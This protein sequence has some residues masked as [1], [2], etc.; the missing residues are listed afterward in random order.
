[1]QNMRSLVALGLSPCFLSNCPR[2][3]NRKLLVFKPHCSL[4]EQSSASLRNTWPSI[5]LSLFGSGFLLGPL[6]DGLH[7]RVNLVT[8][9]NGSIDIGPLHTNIWVNRIICRF[10]QVLFNHYGVFSVSC[11]NH[12]TT[13]ISSIYLSSAWLVAVGSTLAWNVLLHCWVAATLHR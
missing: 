10:L 2:Y 6:I 4:R 11:S 9:L 8:Y 12:Y 1:M 7:S 3:P 13:K 5:S